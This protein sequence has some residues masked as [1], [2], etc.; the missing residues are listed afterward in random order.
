MSAAPP[1]PGGGAADD[2]A[3]GAP[4]LP[5]PAPGAP[6]VRLVSAD[7]E[8]FVVERRIAMASGFLRN[9]LTSGR[10]AE[11]ARGEVSFPSISG[12]ALRKCIE[13]M[14]YKVRHSAPGV[15]PRAP[16]PPFPIPVEDG[17]EL[18]AAANYLD[19]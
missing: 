10:W 5:P 19:L 7:G 12:G 4:A 6:T 2:D 3:A 13:Y 11:A 14:H 1:S 8:A 17:L 16:L 9:L 15:D 18:L